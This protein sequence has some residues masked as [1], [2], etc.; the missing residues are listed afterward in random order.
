MDRREYL[1]IYHAIRY[2]FTNN[3]F[4]DLPD[5]LSAYLYEFPE[6]FNLYFDPNIT[7]E[8]IF[9]YIA[10]NYKDKSKSLMDMVVEY[11]EGVNG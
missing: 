7:L 8:D 6:K 9:E 3:I 1:P 2:K 10:I 4:K 11:V 5:M